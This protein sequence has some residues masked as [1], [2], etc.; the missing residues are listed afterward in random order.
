MAWKEIW[1]RKG[2]GVQAKANL[3]ALICLDGFDT[4]AGRI[5]E[6]EWERMVLRARERLCITNSQR[7]CEVGCGAGAFLYGLYGTGV[8]R[9]YGVDYSG[10]LLAISA[11]AMPEGVFVVAEASSIPFKPAVFDAVVS[12]SVFQYFPNH[13]YAA[14]AFLEM[15]RVLRSG[16]RGL[17]LDINDASKQETFEAARRAQMPPGEYE[18]LYRDL[19]HLFFEKEWWVNLGEKC[20]IRVS[21]YEQDIAG[22]G[23][24]P[25]RYNALFE[26]PPGS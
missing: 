24:A 15:V 20:G 4:G 22:Y 8:R 13:A 12:N 3:Q 6:D 2:A 11:A 19:P 10:S 26:K 16:G 23:N 25:F 18:R 1:E 21:I 9:V 17:V 7:V 5:S 14:S